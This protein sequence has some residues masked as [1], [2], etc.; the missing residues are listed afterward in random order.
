MTTNCREKVF[1]KDI[2]A[3]SISVDKLEEVRE[4]LAV[5]VNLETM[6]RST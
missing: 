6:E 4:G 1:K 3:K 5:R 2:W